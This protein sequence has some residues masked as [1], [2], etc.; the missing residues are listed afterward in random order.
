MSKSEIVSK[1]ILDFL[2]GLKTNK[3][4]MVK[5]NAMLDA[6][7]DEKVQS[8]LSELIANVNTTLKKKKTPYQLFSMR[9]RTELKETG[10]LKV[11][12][13]TI[14]IKTEWDEMEEMERLD[15]EEQAKATGWERPVAKPKSRHENPYLR[16]CKEHRTQVRGENPELKMT[17]IAKILGR[18]WRELDDERKAAYKSGYERDQNDE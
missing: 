15:W 6:W 3:N 12:V 16:F 2:N 11:G 8:E 18:M 9:R 10:E 4:G 7:H 13:S 17:D 5:Y 14:Q 1:F